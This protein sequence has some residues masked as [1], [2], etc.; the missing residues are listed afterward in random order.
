M[1]TDDKKRKTGIGAAAGGAL[2]GA[3]SAP[4]FK[5]ATSLTTEANKDLSTSFKYMRASREPGIHPEMRRANIKHAKMFARDAQ[6]SYKGATYLRRIGKGKIA[7]GAGLVAG[8]T[9]LALNNKKKV[10]KNMTISVWGVDHGD[11]VSKVYEKVDDPRKSHYSARPGI[12]NSKSQNVKRG[13]SIGALAGTA[14]G[15][16][17]SWRGAAVGAGLGAGV[18]AGIGAAQRNKNTKG[19]EKARGV[20]LTRMKDQHKTVDRLNSLEAKR[21]DKLIDRKTYKTKTKAAFAD[22][23]ASAKKFRANRKAAFRD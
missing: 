9:A 11:N 12:F 22:D 6:R 20:Y 16:A 5:R 14:G 2:L 19:A 13:A 21:G 7:A 8:G 1:S 3:S 18:G 23:K 15:L 10:K 4:S 17:G